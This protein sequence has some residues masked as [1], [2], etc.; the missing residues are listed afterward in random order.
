MGTNHLVLVTYGEPATANFGQQLVYSWRILLGLTRTV[1]PIPMALLPVI[2]L[3]RARSRNRTW[4]QEGYRSPLEAITARQA[5][6][7][8]QA[9]ASRGGAEWRVH[10]GYEFR[11]PMLADALGALPPDEPAWVVPMY[12]TDSAFT[13]ALSRMVLAN[14]RKPLKA[15]VH[16]VPALDVNQL[17]EVSASHVLEQIGSEPAWSGPGVALVL[18]AHGTLMNPPRPI[19]TGLD[20]TER[21]CREIR[22]RLAPHFGLVVNGWL[23]HSR[24]GRWTEP[25]I[26]EALGHVSAAGLRRVV[27]YPYGFLADNAETEL[28][29]TLVL[30]G[31]PEL[32]A[33]RVPCL[34]DSPRLVGL[35]AN[36]LTA[37][38]AKF[39]VIREGAFGPRE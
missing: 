2:A 23:N 18:A 10:V 11:E 33:R 28:E 14:L 26:Q 32:E 5:A 8:G 6:R 38:A 36:Q 31:R 1:A 34:N 22:V 25:S 16:V 12:A 9:I 29:G 35:L 37:V 15:P 24:G 7:L 17:A 27:Y 4:R 13:H 30:R 20:A 3:A 39:A 19:D 21:L